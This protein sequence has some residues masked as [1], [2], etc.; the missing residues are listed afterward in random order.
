[1]LTELLR[2]AAGSNLPAREEL[3]LSNAPVLPTVREDAAR[4]LNLVDPG[5]LRVATMI[6][7]TS[8]NGPDAAPLLAHLSG[9]TLE[10]TLVASDQLVRLG[11]SPTMAHSPCATRC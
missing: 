11:S 1:M 9:T 7:V 2:W 10:Q 3:T 5:L 8:E 6:A 4:C